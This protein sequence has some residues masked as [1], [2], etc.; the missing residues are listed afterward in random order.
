MT[1]RSTHPPTSTRKSPLVKVLIGWGAFALVG[2]AALQLIK[3]D[4]LSRRK[5]EHRKMLDDAKTG[6]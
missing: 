3:Y 6:Q 1:Y 2:F 5:A 4:I